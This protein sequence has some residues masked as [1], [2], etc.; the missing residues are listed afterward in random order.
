MQ[1]FK[2]DTWSQLEWNSNSTLLTTEHFNSSKMTM[3]Q[4]SN[5]YISREK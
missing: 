5:V 4:F 2:S 1:N 3:E